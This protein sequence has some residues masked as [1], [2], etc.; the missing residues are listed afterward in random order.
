MIRNSTRRVARGVVVGA[1]S[2]GLVVAGAGAAYATGHEAATK[3][4]TTTVNVVVSDTHM[5]GMPEE[6]MPGTMSMTVDPGSVPHGKVK[7]VVQ[8]QGTELHEVVVVKTTTPFDQMQVNAKDKV[9]EKGSKGE[10]EGVGK[11]KT[12]SK[13][14]KLKAGQYVLLCNIAGHYTSGMRAPFTVT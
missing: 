14:L 13:T 6:H 11:G 5:P 4:K 9:S 8:N 1:L 3:T 10:I 12:K 7:F 2:V